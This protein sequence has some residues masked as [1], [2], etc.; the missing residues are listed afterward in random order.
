MKNPRSSSSNN[1]RM[2]GA[3]VLT[4]VMALSTITDFAK[5]SSTYV[6]DNLGSIS[7]IATTPYY[8]HTDT[9]TNT[10]PFIETTSCRPRSWT[11]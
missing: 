7:Y 10:T 1:L 2:L 11:R 6:T 9:K 4:L 3:V 8:N 5:Y